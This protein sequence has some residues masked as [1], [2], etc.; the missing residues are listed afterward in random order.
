MKPTNVFYQAEGLREIQHVEVQTEHSV[1]VLK[2]LILGLHG[3]KAETFIFLED[4]ENPLDETA[5]IATL[6]KTHDVKLHV[7]GCRKIEVQVAFAGK[8]AKH[9]FAPG[10]TI[11]R[12]KKWATE[13]F[14]MTPDDASEHMLQI[15]GTHD[16]PAAGTHLGALTTCH[17]CHI[18]FDLVPDQRVNG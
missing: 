9:S 15:A 12:V 7:H 13:H 11:A 5:I 10:V 16:R 18:S 8:T 14:G 1:A 2:K 4:G 3:L 17:S 6:V